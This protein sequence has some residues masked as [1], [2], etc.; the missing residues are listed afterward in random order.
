M[1]FSKNCFLSRSF[2]SNHT[3]TTMVL[4]YEKRGI[5]V[6]IRER[7]YT[8]TTRILH[9]RDWR[10]GFH[11]TPP[12][13]TAPVPSKSLAHPETGAI[14]TFLVGAPHSSG[15]ARRDFLVPHSISF[16]CCRWR[17]ERFG[18]QHLASGSAE[19]DRVRSRITRPGL[20]QEDSRKARGELW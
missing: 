12:A 4:P 1:R 8:F 9:R 17:A 10:K 20:P 2:A 15:C 13:R 7:F 11:A 19:T 14:Q 5:V 6:S 3:H 16:F 18:I